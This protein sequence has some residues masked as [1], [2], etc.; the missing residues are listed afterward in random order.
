SMASDESIRRGVEWT[1]GMQTKSGGW[2]SWEPAAMSW[3]GDRIFSYTASSDR[4]CAE[5]T[6]HVLE[7]LSDVSAVDTRVA[8]CGV[9]YLRRSQLS[10]G[11]GPGRWFVH[12]ISG[13]AAAIL[14][15]LAGGV[16]ASDPVVRRG[17]AWL[18]STQ[19]P[20]G[21]WGEDFRAL[22]DPSWIGRGAST[23]SQ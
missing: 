19:N 2:A 21:G 16:S 10:D 15:L 5:L 13:T 11:S 17:V 1:I 18:T 14:G 22:T 6:A 8:K 3:A 7:M 9:D 23:P 12:H 4:E 20:D